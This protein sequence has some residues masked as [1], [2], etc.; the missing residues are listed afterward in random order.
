M[1]CHHR[2]C[3]VLA[4]NGKTDDLVGQPATLLTEYLQAVYATN[5]WLQAQSL[6]VDALY[7]MMT[8]DYPTTLTPE[9]DALL[10]TL[11]QS[12]KDKTQSQ[13]TQSQLKETFA[14]HL[15]AALGLSG[16]AQARLLED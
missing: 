13:Q 6:S 14:P 5:Q 11:Y 2:R 4:L 12:V 16:A 7:A 8:R 10:R 9:M 3:S 15:A 1:T